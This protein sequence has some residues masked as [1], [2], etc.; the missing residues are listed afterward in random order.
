MCRKT[1]IGPQEKPA[2]QIQ[3]NIYKETVNICSDGGKKKQQ[4]VILRRNRERFDLKI[5]SVLVI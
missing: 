2:S 1:N 5:E 4:D 3:Q